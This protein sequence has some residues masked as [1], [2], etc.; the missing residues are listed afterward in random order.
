MK[1]K[2]TYLVL[3]NNTQTKWH[4]NRF[5]L[6]LAP[7]RP[8]ITRSRSYIIWYEKQ[9]FKGKVG[10][11]LTTLKGRKLTLTCPAFGLPQPAISWYRGGMRMKSGGNYVAIGNT[12]IMFNLDP[13]DTD[14]YTCVARNFAGVTSATTT[15]KVHGK[16]KCT[17]TETRFTTPLMLSLRNDGAFC[18]VTFSYGEVVS[19]AP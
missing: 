4:S 8:R 14:R 19:S 11:N 3:T 17:F 2:D 5:N 1:N 15:L 6:C 10:D 9:P 12:L 18:V 16:N 13:M 7:I